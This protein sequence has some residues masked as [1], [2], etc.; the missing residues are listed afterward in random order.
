MS[1]TT[2][3]RQDPQTVSLNDEEGVRRILVDTVFGL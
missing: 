3:T 2:S 1:T